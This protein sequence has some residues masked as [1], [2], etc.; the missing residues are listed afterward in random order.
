MSRGARRNNNQNHGNQNH[1]NQ[2]HGNRRPPQRRPAPV[3]VW[4]NPGALPQIEPIAVAPEVGAVLRSLGDPP[5]VNG[6]AA[7]KY[8]TDVVER[9]AAIAAAL[10]LSADVLADSAGD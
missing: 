1:N 6:S 2:N 5:M 10:A 9:A 4:S 8:F 7:A 3:D